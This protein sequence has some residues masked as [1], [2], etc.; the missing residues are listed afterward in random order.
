MTPPLHKYFYFATLHGLVRS[1]VYSPNY[2]V[3]EGNQKRPPLY[4]EMMVRAVVNSIMNVYFSPLTIYKDF[5]NIERTIRN[6]PKNDP[7]LFANDLMF[8]DKFVSQ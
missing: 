6:M 8:H 7:Y 3:E 1:L 4:T 5:E 2:R